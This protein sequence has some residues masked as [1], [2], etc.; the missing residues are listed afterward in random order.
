MNKRGMVIGPEGTETIVCV[1]DLVTA[2]SKV[3]WTEEGLVISKGDTIL[4][5]EI[6]S[7]QQV[8]PNELRLALIEEIEEAKL[9]KL[10]SM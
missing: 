9:T 6:R 3:D 10:R 4:P 5:I 8:L 7:G 1:N 2:G